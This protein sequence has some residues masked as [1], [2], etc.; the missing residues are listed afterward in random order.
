[1]RPLIF[2]TTLVHSW[3]LHYHYHTISNCITHFC[4]CKLFIY[5][6]KATATV[7]WTR[8]IDFDFSAVV[9]PNC[10]Q[11]SA[12]VK[13]CTQYRCRGC[14]QSSDWRKII[15]KRIPKKIQNIVKSR[16][17]PLRECILDVGLVYM[18]VLGF[19]I[20]RLH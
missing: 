2:V 20:F 15:N 17:S 14:V 9:C 16:Y 12:E 13:S 7:I 8:M 10:R 11:T 18:L 6:F 1:M 3:S 4:T 5:M 19:L